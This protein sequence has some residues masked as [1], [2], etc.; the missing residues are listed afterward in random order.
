MTTAG[1][2]ERMY[3]MVDCQIHEPLPWHED[4]IPPGDVEVRNAVITELALSSMDAVGVTAAVIA[5]VGGHAEW[6]QHATTSFPRRF[7]ALRS[8]GAAGL[9]PLAPDIAEQVERVQAT[10]GVIGLRV[11]DFGAQAE[12]ASK[13]VDGSF[14][15]LFAAAAR[16][17]FP[18]CIYLANRLDLVPRLVA[19][20]PDLILVIDH[21]GV[22]QPMAV[23][24]G[25]ADVP[26]FKQLP[27]LLRLSR[28][29]NV[30]VKLSGYCT[31]SME[32]FPFPDLR[33]PLLALVEAYGPQRLIWGTDIQRVQ[34]RFRNPRPDAWNTDHYPGR[35]TYAEAVAFLRD[36]EGLSSTD[37]A[38][39][40]AGAHR[41]V[42]GWPPERAVSAGM[43]TDAGL[44]A[45][46]A[47]ERR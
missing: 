37:R 20:H 39:I 45:P 17:R 42:F 40:F 31:L 6:P 44:S 34:G 2:E 24:G 18:V 26:R 12:G 41:R 5:S 33:E 16:L 22:Q 10:A 43:N 27:A 7:A 9:D 35:H 29:D 23:N 4:S 25:R 14:A 1:S 3:E 28:F 19:A 15:A 11:S 46:C 21:V 13:I 36:V 38:T 32:P 8:A 47:G 30:V